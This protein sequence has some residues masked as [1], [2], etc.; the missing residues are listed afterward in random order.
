MPTGL[1]ASW[2][3]ESRW[4]VRL[5]DAEDE[6]VSTWRW[7]DTLGDCRS[8]FTDSPAASAE[9]KHDGKPYGVL[10]RKGTKSPL[11]RVTEF[12]T[13]ASSAMAAWKENR[14]EPKGT[15]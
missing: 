10:T 15:N 14:P 11:T 12:Q 4:Q 7:A 3:R 8:D 5:L 1:G 13:D 9:I 6:P 2:T